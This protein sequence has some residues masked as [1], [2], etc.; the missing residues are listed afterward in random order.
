[1]RAKT[2]KCNDCAQDVDHNSPGNPTG[3]VYTSEELQAIGEVAAEEDIY[4]CP[5]RFTRD[6]FT[7]VP[8]M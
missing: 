4:I 6:S 2:S 3:S 7:T 5:T 1:M 8:N